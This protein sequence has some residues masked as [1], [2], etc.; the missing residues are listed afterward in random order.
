MFNIFTAIAYLDS[1]R[2]YEIENTNPDNPLPLNI[3]VKISKWFIINTSTEVHTS[4]LLHPKVSLQHKV[5]SM[6][7]QNKLLYLKRFQI[8]INYFH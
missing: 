5:R 2:T 3:N 4:L 1:T 7:L 8:I 6:Y